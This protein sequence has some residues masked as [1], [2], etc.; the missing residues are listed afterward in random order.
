[1][2]LEHL[3]VF[4]CLPDHRLRHSGE[5][6]DL[7]AIALRRRSF[8]DGMEEDDRVLVLDRVE[9]HVR[10]LPVLEREARQLEV[11]RRKERE[12]L[13]ALGEV[14][15]DRPRKRKPVERRSA[16]ADLV[17]QYQARRR[18]VVQDRGALG[19]L[20]HER[21]RARG[22]IVA[23]PIRVKIWSSGPSRADFAG[24]NEPVCAISA[25]SATWRM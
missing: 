22:E 21:R 2:L 25:I 14:T 15:R 8:L 11:M 23:A 16:A 19:H 7:Q 3:Q 5:P 9:V 18:R 4:A 12:R 24:T 6:R 13:V 1:L 10:H 20:D 17:H